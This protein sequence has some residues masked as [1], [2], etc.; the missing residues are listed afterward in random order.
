MLLVNSI[1]QKKWTIIFFLAAIVNSYIESFGK[2]DFTIY[3]MASKNIFNNIN[4][5]SVSY[6]DGYYYYYSLFFATIIYPFLLLPFFWSSFIWLLFNSIL[7]YFIIK[8]TGELLSI[9]FLSKS[10][11]VLFYIIL[12][13]FSARLIREN[14]HSGQVTILILFLSLYGLD[15]IFNYKNILIGSLFIALAI[16]IKL[17]PIVILPY[18]LYRKEWRAFVVITLF[19]SV[20]YLAPVL[21]M[22]NLFYSDCMHTW[23]GL[24]NPIN[25]KHLL[26]VEERSFHGLGT[27]ITTLLIKSTGEPYILSIKRNIADVSAPTIISIIWIVKMIFI[28]SFIG[29]LRTKPFVKLYTTKPLLME[30]SYLMGLIPLIFPHQQHYAFLFLIPALSLVIYFF[31]QEEKY[32]IVFIITL[33]FVFLCINLKLLL[34]AFNDYYD[35]FKILTYGGIVL[36]VLLQILNSKNFSNKNNS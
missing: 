6:I 8:K 21:W 25:Q 30:W 33:L 28:L 32:S 16:N 36:L 13:L 9:H 22:G 11:Q 7:L 4:P 35:H 5:Y 14:Y 12:L 3:L 34:G 1:K 17:L 19:T 20:L 27:L 18:L 10:K 2:S 26:D 23:Y 15:R 24:I 29:I 31:L